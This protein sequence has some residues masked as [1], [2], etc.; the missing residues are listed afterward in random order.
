MS[1][2]F[3]RVCDS[4]NGWLVP[5]GF[6]KETKSSHYG[7]FHFAY[8]EWNFNQSIRFQG[9]QHGW[10]EGFKAMQGHRN[11]PIGLH[12]IALY[13]RRQKKAFFVGKILSCEN[14]TDLACRVPYPASF[15]AHVNAIG[16]NVAVAR[17]IWQVQS[18]NLNSR[19]QKYQHTPYSN[20]RFPI[21]SVQLVK[22]P[23]P[24][25]IKYTR[26]GALLVDGYPQREAIWNSLP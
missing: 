17:N 22:D 9:I 20:M 4:S 12:D 7:N 2:Y 10:L 26:Y 21:R 23:I 15:A 5:S 14:I 6:A 25:N 24:I 13:V 16:G 1:R 18:V 8:E 19:N 11:V 3:C